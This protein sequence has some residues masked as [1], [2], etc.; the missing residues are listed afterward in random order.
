VSRIGSGAPV[1]NEGTLELE[2]PFGALRGLTMSE[3]GVPELSGADFGAGVALSMIVDGV[4][5]LGHAKGE[6]VI[7]V[8]RGD[9]LFA[10]G[11]ACTH[12]GAPLADGLVVDETIRCPWH[13]ACFSLRTGEALRAPALNPIPCRR[14]EQ[15]DGKAYVGDA[16]QPGRAPV[17]AS[18]AST[19]PRP[20]SIVIIGGGAAGN[21]AAEMLRREGHVGTITMLSADDSLPCDRPNLSKN[22][23]AG[24]APEDWIPLRSADFYRDH[25]IELKLK[26]R[27]VAID[28]A[29]REVRLEDGGRQP[30]DALLLATGADPVRLAI[31]GAGLPHVHCLRTWADS[32]ALVAAAKNARR[33]VVIGASFIG[34]EVAASLRARD[35]DVHVVGREPVPMVPVLGTAVGAF[36][37]SLHEAHG[38]TFHLATT[39]VSID[40]RGVTLSDGETIAADLVVVGIGVRPAIA[41]AE[42]AGLAIDRGVVVDR[43]LATSVAGIYAAGDIARWPDR[44]SGEPIRVEHWVVAERQGQLAAR[45]MLGAREPFDAVPFFWTEQYDFALSYVGHA[46]RFD[47]VEIDGSL[48]ARDCKITYRRGGRKLAVAIVRRDLDGLREEVEFERSLAPNQR[49]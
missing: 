18:V 8:R 47:A 20:S 40:D 30:Y 11:A 35:V 38:V 3:E 5:L 15:R 17:P 43:H 29:A 24:S 1:C 36:I 37:R 12:Y 45:N 28:T 32:R 6:P 42:Q 26:T 19:M 22:Y 10:V 33:A 46:E 21:A 13:H 2:L 44:L 23:L 9:D 49:A 7:L 41:L 25:R 34:L 39:P 31:P 27:V 48:E 4:P 16:I 14:V